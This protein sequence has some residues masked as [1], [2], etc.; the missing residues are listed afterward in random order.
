MDHILANRL[1]ILLQKSRQE[2]ETIIGRILWQVI[3]GHCRE[4]GHQIGKASQFVTHAA[5]PNAPWPT[6]DERDAMARL[7]DVSLF[8][9]PVRIGAMGVTCLVF[10]LPVGSVVTG[11]HHQ[12]VLRKPVAI[13]RVQ[14]TA[15]RRIH[16]ADEIS[17]IASLRFSLELS[18]WQPWRVRTC[19]REIKEEWLLRLRGP[20]ID[21]VHHLRRQHRQSL[22]DIEPRRHRTG[23]PVDPAWSLAARCRRRWLLHRAVVFEVHIGV[24]I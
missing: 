1:G 6:G 10:K 21:D 22:V 19:H 2:V 18:R 8:A 15:N 3:A 14:H 20:R 7:P 13:E 17:I 24:H 11:K 4:R 9:L 23:P 5:R 12:G 16:L